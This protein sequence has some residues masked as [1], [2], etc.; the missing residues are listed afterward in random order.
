MLT[1]SA[2]IT[3]G[4]IEAA[5]SDVYDLE[6]VI[7]A[8]L[9]GTHNIHWSTWTV[10]KRFGMV[11][12]EAVYD[13]KIAR[14][15]YDRYSKTPVSAEAIRELLHNKYEIAQT[16][17][18]LDDIKAGTIKMHWNEVTEFS[19]LAKTIVEH[20]GKMSNAMPLSIEK[21]VIDLVK[22]RLTKTKHRL[23][24]IRC[25]KWERVLE[26]KDVPEK[27][28]CPYCKSAL[29]TASFW[30]DDEM[31]KLIRTKLAGGK[32]SAEDNHR[33]D[34][35]WKMASLINNFGQKAIIVLSGHGVGVD[36][37]ARILRNYI[38]DEQMYRAIYE[39]ERQYVITR[40]FWAD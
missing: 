16:Q 11:A 33:F 27:I 12:R 36:T 17:Q 15:I 31:S 10:S 1:S 22:E 30:S 32:L 40:G 37:A 8:A 39:A 28:V 14:M 7:I 26:T 25:G 13:K 19:D 29:I 2:R 6:P 24:C 35:A 4:R 38:E 3:Q 21:G 20:S 5:L 23:I 34:R 9:T 18:L